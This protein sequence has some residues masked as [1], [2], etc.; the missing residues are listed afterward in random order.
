[1]ADRPER[2]VPAESFEDFF[3]RMYEPLL[4]F[5]TFWCGSYHDAD[6]AVDTVM[7]AMCER[8]HEIKSPAAYARRA[9][10]RT[11]IKLRRDRG[12]HRFVAVPTDQL[13]ELVDMVSDI[14]RI[15]GD[16]WVQ[17]LLGTLP[18]TQY[19]VLS[20][21]LDGLS[22]SEISDELRR[23]ESTIRQNYKLARDR[24]RPAVSEYDR[25]RPPPP[26]PRSPSSA[27]PPPSPPPPRSS[28]GQNVDRAGGER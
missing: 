4:S 20:R 18:P 11:I 25:T 15:S 8:W 7:V 23:S 14:D 1:M 19:A 26:P 24:L 21:F 10:P 16:Q 13:P 9:V 27:P 2:P 3:K 12:D 5:A 6:D 28:Q 22:M 17:E